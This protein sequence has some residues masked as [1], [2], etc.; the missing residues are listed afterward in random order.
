MSQGERFDFS[1]VIF[2]IRQ[3]L[4]HL[5]AGQV[6]KA[7][8][9]FLQRAPQQ[10]ISNDIMHPDASS[11]NAGMPAAHSRRGDDISVFGRRA[12]ARHHKRVPAFRQV[13]RLG[14][15]EA[16]TNLVDWEAVGVATVQ[17]DGSFEFEDAGADKDLCRFYRLALPQ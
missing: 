10:V 11:L 17:S 6:G 12:H 13:G 5:G 16:S 1:S 2:V 15:I 4:I 3:A 9:R 7:A 8:A 14:L